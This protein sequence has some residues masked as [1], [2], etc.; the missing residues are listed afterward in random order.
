MINLLLQIF[1]LLLLLAGLGFGY[2]RWIK[3]HESGLGWQ[4]KGLLLL[5]V[6]TLMGGFIG[7]PFWWLDEVRS[8][9]WDLPPLA[10][11]MLASAGWA[12][13]VVCWHVLQR[14][15]DRR[16]RL[17]MILLAVYLVPLAVAA[18]L[19]HLD[20]F[21][22]AAPITY[23]FFSIVVLM[24][25]GSMWYLW[26]QPEAFADE[27]ADLEPPAPAVRYWLMG[28]AAITGLWGLALFVTDNGPSAFIWVWSGDLLTSR[29]I[30]VMLVAI[31]VGS[32]YS[33]PARG[34]VR[35]MLA[36]IMTYGL[37]LAVAS[38]WNGVAGLPIK[39]SYTIVFGIIFLVSSLFFFRRSMSSV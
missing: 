28:V 34:T 24:C 7:S 14:P 36:M 8:F 22:F 10:S 29:L 4:E 16:L 15:T 18:L 23:A 5:V 26:R 38:M 25:I 11:R 13:F 21:D 9:S 6:L 1:G 19:F 27:P 39:W 3:P 31:A 32:V 37:G 2:W 12:F 35:P 30:G 33:L 17:V 20:R